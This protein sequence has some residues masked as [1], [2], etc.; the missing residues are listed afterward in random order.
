MAGGRDRAVHS[1]FG[2]IVVLVTIRFFT[3]VIPVVPRAA[4]FIDIPLFLV[5]VVAAVVA[6]PSPRGAH[7]SPSACRL[8]RLGRWRSLR[9]SSSTP[10]RG[11]SCAG[12]RIHLRISR[13]ARCLRGGVPDL[14][15]GNAR[16]LSRGAGRARHRPAYGRRLDRRPRFASTGNADKVSGNLLARTRISSCSSSRRCITPRRDLYPG[17]ANAG[18]PFVPVLI[19]A[20]FVVILLAQYRA[21]LAT[22]W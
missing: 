7:T 19:P 3:E 11:R 12:D 14:A 13:T 21:L 15:P 16:S 8:S 2:T 18:R 6:P 4:N 9:R 17:T 20:I 5:L 22:R 10:G 1:C